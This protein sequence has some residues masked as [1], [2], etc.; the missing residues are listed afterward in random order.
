M[1][2][3]RLC[4]LLG[5]LLIVLLFNT[6]SQ[7]QLLGRRRQ[8]TTGSTGGTA[9]TTTITRS[10]G[11]TGGAPTQVMQRPRLFQRKNF[12]EQ[13]VVTPEVVMNSPD[14]EGGGMIQCPFCGRLF[15]VR[16]NPAP[17]PWD[18]GRRGVKACSCQCFCP[19]CG[20]K[21]TCNCICNGNDFKVTCSNCGT[22]F[23]CP[24]ECT[25]NAVGSCK[26][27]DRCTGQP[28]CNCGCPECKCGMSAK[29]DDQT[30]LNPDRPPGYKSENPTATPVT[31]A[32][33]KT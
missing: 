7:A 1:S 2:W 25:T 9:T 8:Q 23:V 11:S 32:P 24:C 6:A 13:S 15:A 14:M 29:K 4:W 17:A 27:C 10:Y 5:V 31:A 26:C 20:T 22:D 21:N 18:D 12:V 33:P 30:P 19:K 3:K 16:I 28:G